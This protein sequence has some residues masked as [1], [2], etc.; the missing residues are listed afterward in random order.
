MKKLILILIV[1]ILTLSSAQAGLY[2]YYLNGTLDSK[3][4][5]SSNADI[6]EQLANTPKNY[7]PYPSYTS[8]KYP[9][10]A[11]NKKY[12]TPVFANDYYSNDSYYSFSSDYKNLLNEKKYLR[13]R[14][15]AI[16]VELSNIDKYSSKYYERLRRD[17]KSERL[18][19]IAR[20]DELQNIIDDIED[21]YTYQKYKNNNESYYYNNYGKRIYS[22]TETTRL[23]NSNYRI[24]YSNSQY[25]NY[26]YYSDDYYDS[27][28]HDY[29]D[30]KYDS[31]YNSPPS[32]V[33]PNLKEI[34]DGYIHIH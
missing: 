21:D 5:Y 23:Q 32:W 6:V 34:K 7:Y 24:C 3:V 18:Y 12:T 1:Y 25:E 20:Q 2:E 9:S 19:V 10:Y 31:D 33:N 8:S 15:A 4:K 22:A 29:T 30:S 14:E 26:R 17:L 27:C 16:N 13:S 11:S 28:Y